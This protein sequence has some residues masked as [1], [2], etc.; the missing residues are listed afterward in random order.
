MIF[1]LI[2]F[3]NKNNQI[4]QLFIEELKILKL[5]SNVFSLESSLI[6]YIFSGKLKNRFYFIN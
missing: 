2:I 1:T 6:F 5:I 3:K 4:S